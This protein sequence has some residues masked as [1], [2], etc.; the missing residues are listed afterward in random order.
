MYI[1]SVDKV[2]GQ[3]LVHDQIGFKI[4]ILQQQQQHRLQN[5]RKGQMKTW[6]V[7]SSSANLIWFYFIFVTTIKIGYEWKLAKKN[8]QVQHFFSSD[9]IPPQTSHDFEI[10]YIQILNK[11]NSDVVYFFSFSFRIFFRRISTN[12]VMPPI[13]G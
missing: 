7:P 13:V 3:K 9:F 6:I 10:R 12:I 8:I 2:I 1:K 4:A 11:N 5:S